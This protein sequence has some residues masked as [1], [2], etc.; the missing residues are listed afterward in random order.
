MIKQAIEKIVKRIDL[1]PSEMEKSF[2]EIMSGEAD[3]SQ[4]AAFITALRMKGETIDEITAA[5]KVMRKFATKID[6]IEQNK[7]EILLD[8]CGTGGSG[9]DTFNISTTVA[10]VVAGCGVKVAKHGNRSASSQC[11][12]ADVL[13]ELGV[14]LDIS[15][16][17][18]LE[19]INEIGIGFMFA[20]LFHSAMKYAV[21]VRKAIGIRTIFNI[22]GPLSNPAGATSQ[23]LGV[24]DRS[25]TKP[26]ASVLKNLGI[27]HAF[28]VY[29]L[30]GMDEVTTTSQTQISEVHNNRTRTYKITPEKFGFKRADLADLK[31]GSAADNANLLLDI[32]N[33]KEGSCRDIVL[34]NSAYALLASDKAESVKQ[35]ISL[36]EESIDSGC[37]LSK[38]EALK[39]FTSI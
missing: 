28:V 24:Y 18:V 16:L 17:E 14:N 12:S 35:G 11:G 15:P 1:K 36:A 38:L 19:C 6:A 13:E 5:A 33:G 9:L 32:L 4:I 8:T 39:S 37:A 2:S 3:A 30:D 26:I 34:L 20:P 29:G 21:P 31:G 27:K 25:L 23:V 7:D 10:F 22:L